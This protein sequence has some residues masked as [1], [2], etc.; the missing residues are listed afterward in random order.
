M[1]SFKRAHDVLQGLK[2]LGKI[3]DK[4]QKALVVTGEENIQ[5]LA[6]LT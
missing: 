2:C 5:L 6:L 4:P 1:I 3:K